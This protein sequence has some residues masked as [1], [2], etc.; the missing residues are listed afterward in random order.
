M[1]ELPR[2]DEKA[3]NDGPLKVIALHVKNT[4]DRERFVI[5]GVAPRK[6]GPIVIWAEC[7]F[8]RRAMWET[9]FRKLVGSYA[10]P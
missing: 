8:T 2:A 6:E 4:K 3:Q 10:S 7:D 1:P 9:D 5:L